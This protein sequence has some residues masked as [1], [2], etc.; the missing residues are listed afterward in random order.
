LLN[1]KHNPKFDPFCDDVNNDGVCNCKNSIGTPIDPLVRECTLADEIIE[2][3]MSNPPYW[4]N[5]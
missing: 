5:G 4:P 1:L 2:P 3:T